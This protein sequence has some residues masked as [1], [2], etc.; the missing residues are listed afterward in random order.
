[1]TI[2]KYTQ[3]ILIVEDEE[4][5]AVT[6]A[7]NLV[8][9]GFLEPLRAHNGDEGLK[10][11]LSELPDLILLDI[12]MPKADGMTMLKKLRADINGK[13]LKVILLTNLTADE[14]VMGSVLTTEPSY[15]LVKSDHS[16]DDVM[17]KIRFVLDIKNS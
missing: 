6:L 8:N 11:A 13:N 9:A 16:I 4:P 17:E 12:V 15:Y 5:M 2:A 14:S 7:D 3:K 1:M 10:M